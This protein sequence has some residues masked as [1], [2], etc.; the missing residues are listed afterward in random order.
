[1]AQRIKALDAKPNDQ[2]SIPGSH[3]VERTNS[4]KLSPDLRTPGSGDFL[5]AKMLQTFP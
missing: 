1:M 5:N 2:S 3:I 4:C